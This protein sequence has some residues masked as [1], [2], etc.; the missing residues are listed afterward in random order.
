MH[1]VSSAGTEIGGAKYRVLGV[2]QKSWPNG[3]PREAMARLERTAG[4]TTSTV[5][6]GFN[7][8]FVEQAGARELLLGRYGRA[9]SG[10]VLRS[11]GELVP[12]RPG[13]LL[14]TLQERDNP[15]VPLVLG[16]A[17]L[18]TLGVVLAG[19]ERLRRDRH[20]PTPRQ[21]EA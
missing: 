19:W 15:S 3:M 2:E 9:R 6:I 12:I 13:E 5:T 16:V 20:Y 14:V 17:G 11:G 8:P 10:T 7:Q 18:I 4:G 21:P 1:V